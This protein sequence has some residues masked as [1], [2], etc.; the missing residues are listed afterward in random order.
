MTEKILTER[1]II[2]NILGYV[3]IYNCFF[4]PIHAEYQTN[5][6]YSLLSIQ[7]PPQTLLQTTSK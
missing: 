6:I 3:E 2:F 1:L 4:E 7:K 5:I